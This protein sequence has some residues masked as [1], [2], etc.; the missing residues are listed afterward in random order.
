M[1]FSMKYVLILHVLNIH[2]EEQASKQQIIRS[3]YAMQC[4]LKKIINETIVEMM[5]MINEK[6]DNMAGKRQ[7]I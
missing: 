7:Y 2:Q 1:L 4:L 5:M 6:L 3:I